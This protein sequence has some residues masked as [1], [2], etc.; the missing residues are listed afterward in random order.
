MHIGGLPNTRVWGH[1]CTSR[2]WQKWEQNAGWIPSEV[3]ELQLSDAVHIIPAWDLIS[4]CAMMH[5]GGGPSRNDVSYV[6]TGRIYIH[7]L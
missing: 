7:R 1:T 5:N 6:H 2:F 4:I 3:A